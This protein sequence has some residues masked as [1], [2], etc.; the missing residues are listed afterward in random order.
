MNKFWILLAFLLAPLLVVVLLAKSYAENPQIVVKTIPEITFEKPDI[1]SVDV[2][3]E[4]L[5]VDLSELTN[6]TSTSFT[7]NRTHMQIDLGN[8]NIVIAEIA[9]GNSFVEE[10]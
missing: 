8:D 6:L 2:T 5:S 9:M 7:Q 10:K 1:D 4:K 3:F